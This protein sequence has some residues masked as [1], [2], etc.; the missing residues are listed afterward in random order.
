MEVK[1]SGFREIQ[2]KE[3]SLREIQHYVAKQIYYIHHHHHHH[4]IIIIII[5]IIAESD[6]LASTE[7][8]YAI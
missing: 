5:V 7:T 3:K 1:V 2:N 8:Q 4:R 6:V